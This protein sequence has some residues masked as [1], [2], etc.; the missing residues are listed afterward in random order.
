M[1]WSRADGAPAISDAYA[2][3]VAADA[4]GNVVVMGSYTGAAVVGCT[5][6]VKP[7][8]TGT[9]LAKYD[10]LGNLIWTKGFPSDDQD[11]FANG[12]VVVDASDAIYVTGVASG[13]PDFGGGPIPGASENLFVAKYDADGHHLWSKRFGSGLVQGLVAI[14]APA[15]DSAGNLVL[16][17]SF[18]GSIDFG[19]GTLVSANPGDFASADVFVAKLSPSGDA[20]FSERF[21]ANGAAYASAVA[22][23]ASDAIVLAGDLRGSLSV[24][25]FTLTADAGAVN[26]DTFLVK[27]DASG[28]PIWARDLADAGLDATFGLAVDASTGDIGLLASVNDQIALD[29][30]HVVVAPPNPNGFDRGVFVARFDGSGA[31]R[32]ATVLGTF[33]GFGRFDPVRLAFDH[34]GDV[35]A[36]LDDMNGQTGAVTKI[37]PTGSVLWTRA[38]PNEIGFSGTLGLDASDDE[39]VAGWLLPANGSYDF[40]GGPVSGSFFVAKLAP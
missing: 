17:G 40:G 3:G 32:W 7:T 2:H 9:F 25:P 39:L 8:F 21:A 20:L 29:P 18:T 6:F 11:S 1:L 35:V 16:A 36:V 10:P 22:L 13:S 4:K 26:G 12:A 28:T 15:L 37:D 23:D 5:A 19:A 34:Q 33:Q 31:P 14:A 30:A 38:L 27:L 24:G